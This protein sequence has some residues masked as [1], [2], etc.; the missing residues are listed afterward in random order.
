MHLALTWLPARRGVAMLFWLTMLAAPATAQ[1]TFSRTDSLLGIEAT[2][3]SFG[4]SWG[5]FNN[6]GHV[7]IWS[8]NHGGVPNLYLNVPG[9]PFVDIWPSSWIPQEGDRHGGSWGDFDND[10]LRDLYITVGAQNGEGV[11]SNQ[12]YHNL[13]AC[14]FADIARASGTLDSLGRGRFA[15]WI[16][17]DNDGLL[18]IFV[19]NMATPNRL[20]LNR[21]D[22]TFEEV[23]NAGGLG[24][25]DLWYAAWTQLDDD[26]LMDVV[27]AG[28]WS[29]DLALFHNSGDGRF[30]DV[31]G[32]SGLPTFLGAVNGLC[33][34]DYD[35]DGDEDLYCSRGSSGDCGDAF[36]SDST[37]TMEFLSY[38]P[39]R[40]EEES[41][42]DQIE[43]AAAS[44][45]LNVKLVIDWDSRPFDHIFL[46]ASGAHPTS[47][48]FFLGNGTYLG[49]PP[50][51]PG[52]SF[53][54]YIWQDAI[55]G[56][57][58]IE[59]S[60]DF[61]T[62]H[63]VGGIVTV[64]S[65]HVTGFD[66]SGIEVPVTPLWMDDRFYRNRGNGT[67]E[68]VTAAAGIADSL[69][70]HSCVS[71]DFDNDG[72][73]DLFVTNGRN[74][75]GFLVQ[76]GPCLLYLNNRDGTFRECATA[77]GADNRV[78]GT[79]GGGAWAD[80]D[81]DG[82]PDLFITNGWG[83]FPFNRGPHVLYHNQGNGN[84]WVRLRL[85]GTVSNRDAIGAQV[86]IE[87]DGQTQWRTQYGGVNDM[88]QSTMIVHFGLG[89]ATRIETLVIDWPAGGRDVF[90]DLAVDRTY[91]FTEGQSAAVLA[92]PAPP[93]RLRLDP[94]VPTP[95]RERATLSYELSAEGRVRLEIFDPAGRCVRRL[96]DATQYAGR[97]TIPW[98][99][100]DGFGRR[101]PRG[102]Y[103][104][105]L[106]CGEEAVTQRRLV[107]D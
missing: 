75:S 63:R 9:H 67:F 89:S 11:G 20:F 44:G 3:M 22:R 23:P 36:W 27:L 83:V 68:D 90:H 41:G 73:L 88:S 59:A 85:I 54:C 78:D 42:A 12:L 82:F 51:V 10:G 72:W 101:L 18:D 25:D 95:L 60:T 65:G 32:P 8:G 66:T 47:K 107:L 97:H 14:R 50:H 17:A 1:L 24:S 33:W 39:D 2:G 98:D 57:W 77:C 105:R 106:R 6:D 92:P 86:R 104:A 34:I 93:L 79:G 40:P 58:H 61:G 71:V 26:R 43:V 31:T 45:G 13:G 15:Y 81:E 80:Y 99:A 30:V 5:D 37:T 64:A 28:A 96:I 76:N 102:V 46:G 62:L 35:N 38:L 55:G 70:G 87:A 56:P 84:H 91:T 53:G 52:Q 48:T 4:P 74:V 16:D 100:R 7:D 49:R 103:S 19:G 29:C 21:G 94:V 69:D